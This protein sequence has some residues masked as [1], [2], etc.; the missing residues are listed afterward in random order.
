M[1]SEKYGI[2]ETKEAM[3]FGVTMAMAVDEATQ[4]G[5][6][7]TDVFKMVPALTKLPAAVEGIQ[8]V[9]AEL[10]D[11]SEAERDELILEIENLEFAS[12]YSEQ[13]A[14]QSLRVALELGKLI[15]L[16][17]EAKKEQEDED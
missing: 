4:D 15:V 10:S 8:N 12:E 14:E 7:W 6:Q 2:A 3:I 9:P 5:F 11:L 16:I 13:I 1:S 17:R